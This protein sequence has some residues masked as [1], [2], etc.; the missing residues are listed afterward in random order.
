MT[1]V[2]K[3]LIVAAGRSS[4]LYPLTCN[5]P[6]GL[7]SIG[8]ESIIRRSLRLLKDAG[9]A[10]IAIVDGYLN[11]V[12]REHVGPSVN[13]MYNP[14]FANTNNMA[15]L[16]FGRH[17]VGQDPFVYLHSDVIYSEKLI[18]LL[19]QKSTDTDAGFL[20][21]ETSIDAEAM[22]VRCDK[23]WLVESSKSIPLHEAQGEWTG[24][25]LFN[26][27]NTLFGVIES[28]LQDTSNFNAYDT[29]AFSIMA[30]RGARY[31][32]VSTN[33]EPWIEIDTKED[34]QKAEALFI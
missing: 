1:T 26:Q 12:L 13:Y 3:A 27:T 24:I 14:F 16:W 18:P 32:I 25:T 22:K 4:R 19:L 7:L 28:L 10:D 9:I 6:K 2:R 8:N 17:W 15:S 20:V 30:E 5:K 11:Q 31:R 23:E 34:L 29:M 33:N 21:D